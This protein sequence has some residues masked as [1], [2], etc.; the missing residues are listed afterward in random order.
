[1]I[2][3]FKDFIFDCRVCGFWHALNNFIYSVQ[4]RHTLPFS[5]KQDKILKKWVERE[6]MIAEYYYQKKS[7]KH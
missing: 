2:K 4:Y 5:E 3:I 1:M 6:E 7:M